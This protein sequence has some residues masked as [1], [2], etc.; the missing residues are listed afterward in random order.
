MQKFWYLVGLVRAKIQFYAFPPMLCPT[1]D[2]PNCRTRNPE[3]D[4]NTVE[5][6]YMQ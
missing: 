2:G 5:K 4:A 3:I 6:H 1:E